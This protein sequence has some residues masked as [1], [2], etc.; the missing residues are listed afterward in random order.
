M[1]GDDIS[2]PAYIDIRRNA[3]GVVRRYG[4]EEFFGDLIWYDGNYSCDC[5]CHLF[6]ARAAK[7]QE[8]DHCPCGDGAYAVRITAAYDGR[9][10]YSDGEWP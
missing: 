1:T 8:T 10:L 2:I 6:F 4:P 9:E 3:D 7:E 5:N